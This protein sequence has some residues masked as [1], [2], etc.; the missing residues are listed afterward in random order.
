MFLCSSCCVLLH[1]DPPI[2]RQ[3]LITGWNDSHPMG[4]KVSPLNLMHHHGRWRQTSRLQPTPWYITP[5][6]SHQIETICR[7]IH[8]RIPLRGLVG[9]AAYRVYSRGHDSS[10]GKDRHIATRTHTQKHTD[11]HPQTDSHSYSAW[12]S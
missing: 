8:P 2:P 4:A 1:I 9:W 12:W 3:V 6:M 5:P 11:R 7:C 10:P